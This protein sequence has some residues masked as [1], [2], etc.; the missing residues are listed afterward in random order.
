MGQLKITHFVAYM[1]TNCSNMSVKITPY[2]RYRTVEFPH[3]CIIFTF[4]LHDVTHDITQVVV[5]SLNL[6]VH[7]SVLS[8]WTKM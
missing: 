8:L 2:E 5:F 4:N 6:Q 7:E 1:T 3:V